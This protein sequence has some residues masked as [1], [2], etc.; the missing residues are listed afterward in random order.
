MEKSIITGRK[1][2]G[3]FVVLIGILAL[4][5][6][7]GTYDVD[8]IYL[9]NNYWPLVLI[10]SG[11]FTVITNPASK[12][13]GLVVLAIGILFQL[14]NLNILKGFTYAYIWPLALILIGISIMFSKSKKKNGSTKDVLDS[15]AIFGGSSIRSVSRN[16]RGG[17]AVAIFGGV[18]ID[19]RDAQIPNSEEAVLDVFTA[20]GGV[21]IKV[22][23]NWRI[24]MNGVP[25]F[26][27]WEDNTKG[28]ELDDNAPVLVL[29]CL[30][31]FGGLE[32]R[33]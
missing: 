14:H 3:V 15:I 12:V 25:V 29:K 19:L 6:T 26:G 28:Y 1:V 16:F 20:F 13:G 30:V 2:F 10:F 17:N 11:A 8:I 22:P 9:I 24:V 23:E 27:G 18:D 33:N 4:L 21:E 5:N 32:V 31:A 7:T